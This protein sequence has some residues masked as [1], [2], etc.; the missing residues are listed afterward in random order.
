MYSHN[1]DAT[2][3]NIKSWSSKF[4]DFNV[5]LFD[6]HIHSSY[7]DFYENNIFKKNIKIV[8]KYLSHCLNV[9]K[10]EINLFPY[11][12][13]VFNA[14]NITP[15]NKIKIVILGQDPYFNSRTHNNIEIPEAMGLSFSI[16]KNIKIPSSLRNIYKNLLKNG[17]INKIPEHGNLSFWA[18]QGCL[19]L[20]TILTVQQKH[21]NGHI[22]KWTTLTDSLIK[23]ISDNTKNIVFLLWGS[24]AYKK[25]D[26]IDT[27]KHKIVVSSHPS[28][29]SCNTKFRT[30]N[31]FNET[32]HF[33]E[34][35]KY[36]EKHNK[37]SVIFE[38]I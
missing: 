11:P 21:P 15:L 19:L 10:G 29:L 23:F 34:A 5:D 17:H 2:N 16:P 12:D 9:T 28:G 35:N 6:L 4:P 31:S 14:L 18:H 3:Y 32:D 25:Y 8:N 36:L 7:Q 1:L 33:T 13:L 20:N 24:N 26:L 37:P 22:K 30:F 27:K 38:I